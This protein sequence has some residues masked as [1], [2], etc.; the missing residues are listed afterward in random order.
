[1]A[2]M[3]QNTEPGLDATKHWTWIGYNQAQNLDRIVLIKD[4]TWNGWNQILNQN[5]TDQKHWIGQN[6]EKIYVKVKQKLKLKFNLKGVTG[7]VR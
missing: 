1:M 3:Q 2:W 5:W 4:W 6:F 7:Y